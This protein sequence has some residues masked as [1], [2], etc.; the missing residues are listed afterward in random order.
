MLDLVDETD[1]P[2]LIVCDDV[3]TAISLVDAGGDTSCDGDADEEHDA[4]ADDDAE[5]MRAVSLALRETPTGKGLL[6]LLGRGVIEG[7][8][9]I[10]GDATWEGVG[11]IVRVGVGVNAAD[12][13]CV[14][15]SVLLAVR[16]REGER[17]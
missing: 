1:A 3:T 12:G 2:L 4:D 6:V 15:E 16:D 8:G 5:G 10:D 11:D 17:S 14:V 13:V 9:L 7:V